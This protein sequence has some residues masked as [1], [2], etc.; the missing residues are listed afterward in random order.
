MGIVIRG[1]KNAFRNSLRTFSVTLILALSTGLALVMLLSYQA[2]VAKITTVKETVGTTITISPAGSQG[3]E[4][5]GEP[6][7]QT[8]ITPLAS[9]AHVASVNATLSDRLVNGTSTSLQ[10]AIDAG[11]LGNR[12]GQQSIQ[13]AGGDTPVEAPR[14]QAGGTAAGTTT[15]TR[16]F[17]PPIIATGVSNLSANLGTTTTYT[18]GS[19]FANDSS[20]NVAVIGTGVATKNSLSVGSTFTLYGTEVKVVGIYDSGNTFSNAGIYV[21][22]KALQTLSSQ[23]DQVST[24]TV[25]ATSI[26]EVDSVVT[27]IK[28]KIGADKADVTAN[29]DQA[30]SAL[31]PLENIRTTS[32]YSLFGALIAGAVITLLIM[33]MIVRE[34]RREIG[35]LKAVG[36]SNIG[37]V[38]QFVTEA[39]TLTFIG[40][41]IGGVVGVLLSNPALSVLI[42]S[43]TSTVT[44]AG[45]PG[46]GF[47][48]IA[49]AASGGIRSTITNVQTTIDW[50]VILYGLAAAFIIAAIGSAVPAWAIA[51]VKPADAMRAE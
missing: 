17:T 20:E 23:A 7:T 42:K 22:L 24:A 6:L 48:R 47:G 10:S 18:S 40:S 12:R 30:E 33:M 34:R 27:A 3:F 31:T 38:G 1:I 39:F 25:T 26:E 32:L 11:T 36:S 8:Q 51:K 13:A 21:P 2:V 19:G 50:H 49:L 44:T 45:G 4:G 41:L 14:T 28:E 46:G 35:V 29:K 43:G 37:I 5:G 9:L 16:T 15:R